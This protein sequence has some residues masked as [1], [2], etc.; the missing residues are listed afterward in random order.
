MRRFKVQM[1]ERS[2]HQ[3]QGFELD[4]QCLADVVCFAERHVRREHDVDF[5]DVVVAEVVGVHGVDGENGRMVIP[6]HKGERLVHVGRGSPTSEGAQL[7]V[8]SARP[9]GHEVE[10]NAHCAGG[11]DPPAHVEAHERGDGA[12]DVGDD[13]VAVVCRKCLHRL[14]AV[15]HLSAVEPENGLEH[16]GDEQDQHR[17]EAHL[18]LHVV[19]NEAL[20][21]AEHQLEGGGEHAR[22]E[23]HNAHRLEPGLA[24][25][26]VLWCSALCNELGEE[27]DRAREEV[28]ERVQSA[29]KHRKRA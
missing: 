4:L 21:G 19:R 18:Q 29:R 20:H 11:V 10:R 2:L 12:E 23:D 13:V 25:R 5:T 14:T 28:E 26:V 3:F 7:L 6:C 15:A 22:A 8:A 9:H 17:N 24:C 27:D 16:D 1:H